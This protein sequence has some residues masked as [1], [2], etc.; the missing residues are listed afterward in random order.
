LAIVFQIRLAHPSERERLIELQRRASLAVEQY[1]ERLLASPDAIDIP[2]S[3]LVEGQIRVAYSSAAILGFAAVVTL[4]EN[5]RELDGLFVEPGQWRHGIGRALVEDAVQIA[6]D[7]GM[8]HLEVTAN[9]T[10][11]TFY[12][13]LGLVVAGVTKQG[14]AQPQACAGPWPA[15]SHQVSA[16]VSQIKYHGTLIRLIHGN[17]HCVRI[18]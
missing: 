8:A 3:Q 12:A 5:V 18:L 13:K 9:P 1:R 15:P 2:V 17:R 14:S 7:D 4:G 10:A 11:Q 16:T 6:I